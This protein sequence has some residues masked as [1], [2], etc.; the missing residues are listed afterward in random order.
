MGSTQRMHQPSG[1]V[2]PANPGA[3]AARHGQHTPNTGT[4]LWQCPGSH[5]KL[6]LWAKALENQSLQKSRAW[7]HPPLVWK[8]P[9]GQQ[10]WLYGCTGK[11]YGCGFWKTAHTLGRTRHLSRQSCGEKRHFWAASSN[12][13]SPSTALCG[14]L[15]CTAR[16]DC[17]YQGRIIYSC[18]L[19]EKILSK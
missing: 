19:P 9:W 3:G 2:L 14:S 7:H 4:D 17:K 15:C 6:K 12:L 5:T 16:E 1:K 10:S 11:Q 18:Y 13:P 8:C